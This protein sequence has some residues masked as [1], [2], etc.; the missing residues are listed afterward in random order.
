MGYRLRRD[1]KTGYER[2]RKKTENGIQ[3][4]ERLEKEK[5]D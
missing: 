2:G 5:G 1:W 3:V 4:L